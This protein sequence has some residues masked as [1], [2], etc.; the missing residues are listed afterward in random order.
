[1]AQLPNEFMLCPT[2]PDAQKKSSV[3]L[4]I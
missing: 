3:L 4:E 2:D 1:V